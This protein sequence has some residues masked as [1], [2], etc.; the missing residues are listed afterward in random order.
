MVEEIP[1]AAY[2]LLRAE[3]LTNWLHL[4]LLDPDG[5]ELAR[6]G[7]ASDPRCAVEEVAGT[8]RAEYRVRLRGDDADWGGVY[9]VRIYGYALYD[10]ASGGSAFVERPITPAIFETATDGAVITIPVYVPT[11]LIHR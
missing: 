8:G 1:P 3:V 7:I 5:R 10:Q 9:P 4:A 6:L 11:V 2:A